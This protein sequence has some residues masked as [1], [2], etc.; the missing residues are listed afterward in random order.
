MA[1][2]SVVLTIFNKENIIEMILKAL[3]KYTSKTV[4]E[5]IFVLD[6][7]TDNSESILN[8]MLPN[9]PH[10]ANYKIIKT[11]NVFELR[12]NNAGLK[13][14]TNE[15]AIIVQDDMCIEE[16]NWN[17]RLLQPILHYKDIWAVTART[18]C[19]LNPDGNWYNIKEGPVGHNF[20]KNADFPR[21]LVFVGQVVNRGPLLVTMSVI[22]QIGYFDETL[23][24][25]IGC[26]DVDACLKVFERFGLRCCSFW[27]GYNSPLEWGSTRSGPKVEFVREEEKR[28]NNEIRIRYSNLLKLWN[29]DEVRKINNPI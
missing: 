6:G 29:Y 4:N 27:I 8:R 17:D 25:C 23:P 7:C 9:I 21:N 2:Q 24:G 18:A 20:K 19:S 5:Y 10:N 1:T 11:D 12:A 3:F 13:E 16:L 26:D 22:K 14:C 28:N 15:Y